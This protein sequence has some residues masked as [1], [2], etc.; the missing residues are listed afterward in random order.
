[1]VHRK[2]IFGNIKA[3]VEERK[4]GK[5]ISTWWDK[6]SCYEPDREVFVFETYSA[7]LADMY[8]KLFLKAHA[9][10][11]NLKVLIVEALK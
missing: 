11:L 7:A 9:D 5:F 1:M 10:Y 8:E 2:E 4:D 6:V 3:T